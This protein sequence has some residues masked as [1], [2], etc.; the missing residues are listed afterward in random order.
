[1]A[2]DIYSTGR[3]LMAV[4]GIDPAD[5][6][7]RDRYFP[8]TAAD[9]FNTEKV[10]V[11]FRDGEQRLAPFVVQRKNGVVVSRAGYATHEYVPPKV[12]PKRPISID[13]LERRGFGEALFG[14][15]S[16]QQ[17]EQVL[18]MQDLSELDNMVTRREEA[19]AAQVMLDNAL[20][21]SSIVD[22]AGNTVEDGWDYYDEA[23]NPASYTVTKKW[24]A[25]DAN[26]LGDLAAMARML[27]RNGLPATDFVCAP[28]VA[29]AIV[30]NA[31]VQKLL[32]NRRY[33]LGS[34]APTLEA[35][36]AAVVAQLN[37][38]GRAIS[39]ISY[40]QVYKAE[41]GT[42]TQ[43]VPNGCGILTAPKAGRML[44]GAV[45][46]LEQAD[47]R[48]HTYGQRRVPK[49]VADAE[50][51]VRTLTL[52]SRPLPIP[53]NKNPWVSAKALL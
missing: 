12:A 29:D 2:I 47:G 50:S 42:A 21:F 13:D 22:D 25:A 1:M 43:Y 44:Y 3:L 5:S 41:D 39:V 4:Q 53:N 20:T 30:N 37:V 11:D 10:I 40:D 8:T 6:F 27:T 23:A 46:Q 14:T 36:G 19:M 9:V 28:D 26:I 7:L 17:R 16:P 51:N 52:T 48:I 45:T 33:D 35:P 31:A 49:Y 34:V 15:M 24:G 32:D 18:A 38:G